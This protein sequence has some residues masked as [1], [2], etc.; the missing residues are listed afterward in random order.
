MLT[1]LPTGNIPTR[2]AYLV[3]G[4]LAAGFSSGWWI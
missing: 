4:G 2:F 1:L 3:A